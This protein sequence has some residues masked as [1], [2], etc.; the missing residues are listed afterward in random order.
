M[1]KYKLSALEEL[2]L[3]KK[4]LQEKR[5]VAEQR[6]I[7][8]AQYFGDN[9]GSMISKQVTSSVKEKL[10][11]TVDAISGNSTS[12]S[13]TPFVTKHKSNPWMSA[14]TSNLP[15]I[16]T[17]AW[18]YAKLSLLAFVGKKATSMVLKKLLR[19]KKR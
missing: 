14:I 15:L 9:W 10:S 8:Q 5:K 16:G 6:I 18:R 2:K 13:I 7:Y 12:S 4:T 3:Q 19:R 11:G 1:S 17:V